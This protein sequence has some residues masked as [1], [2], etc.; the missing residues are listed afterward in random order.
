MSDVSFRPPSTPVK[1]QQIDFKWP[2]RPGILIDSVRYFECGFGSEYVYCYSFPVH[3]EAARLKNE[4]C[5]PI[6][7]GMATG[8]PVARIYGQVA[9]SKIALSEPP[10]LLLVFK[11]LAARHL[12]RWLHKRLERSAVAAGTE[13]F[14]SN[15]EELVEMVRNYFETASAN[16]INADAELKKKTRRE[17]TESALPIGDYGRSR[18]QRNEAGLTNK[19]ELFEI[20]LD[21][22]KHG[23]RINMNE[24]AKRFPNRPPNTLNGWVSNWCNGGKGHGYPRVAFGRAAEIVDALKNLYG[25]EYVTEELAELIQAMAVSRRGT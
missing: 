5:F 15:P 1:I 24:V 8:D 3:L 25:D 9:T 7:V 22:A 10:L 14:N 12:E 13:W 19:D 20:W 18:G 23:E 16:S 6:K 11:T 2:T 4:K 21:A 17:Q